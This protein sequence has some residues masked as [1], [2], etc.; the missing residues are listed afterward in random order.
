MMTPE[1]TMPGAAPP[2]RQPH[3]A[4]A[5]SEREQSG[6]LRERAT[7]A[8]PCPLF[9]AAIDSPPAQPLASATVH[10]QIAQNGRPSAE[11]AAT[12]LVLAVFMTSISK[13]CRGL[14]HQ[15]RRCW[16]RVALS[17]GQLGW[18]VVRVNRPEQTITAATLISGYPPSVIVNVASHDAVAEK[19]RA[20]TVNADLKRPSACSP[21]LAGCHAA[22]SGSAAGSAETSQT[23]GRSLRLPCCQPTTSTRNK[24]R[25]ADRRNVPKRPGETSQDVPD[26]RRSH[27]FPCDREAA[28][29]EW[30]AQLTRR[31]SAV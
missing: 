15:G 14:S 7:A 18:F 9:I 3:R 16:N 21:P 17:T 11:R 20:N 8:R 22:S 4:Q 1:S 12:A 30:R 2:S 29:A 13:M 26:S 5:R 6:H 28:R 25:S 23:R 27:Q 31:R 10:P 19:L 24:H